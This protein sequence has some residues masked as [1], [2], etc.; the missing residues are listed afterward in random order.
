ML[1]PPCDRRRER[2]SPGGWGDGDGAAPPLTP[3]H[4]SRRSKTKNDD[5]APEVELEAEGKSS[6]RDMALV[7]DQSSRGA[8]VRLKRG[9]MRSHGGEHERPSCCYRRV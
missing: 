9:R 4:G 5:A 8:G 2:P 1:S 3:P 6:P 7:A